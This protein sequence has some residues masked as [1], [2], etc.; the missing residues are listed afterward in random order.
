MS[1]V[2]PHWF[3]PLA[4]LKQGIAK[5]KQ[6]RKPFLA[7]EYGWDQTNYPTLRGLRAFLES[8]E[9]A[10]EIAG[11]AFWALQA[12][13]DGHGWMPIPAD[14]TDPTT[15]RSSRVDSGGR[16]TTRGSRHWSTPLPTWPHVR[17]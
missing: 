2:Y 11:D 7:Y 10:P 8:L 3:Q 5:C 17:R 6:A 14:T 16:C 15:A 4:S 1:F 12:H 13:N 9:N